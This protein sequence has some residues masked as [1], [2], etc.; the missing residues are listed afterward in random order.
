ML[1]SRENLKRTATHP[2]NSPW[3]LELGREHC[4]ACGQVYVYETGYYCAGCDGRICSICVEE[5]VSVSVFCVH[6]KSSEKD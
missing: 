6:C 4:S 3:W 2:N 1:L 5:T